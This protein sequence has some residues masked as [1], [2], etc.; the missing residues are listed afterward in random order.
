M[1]VC[2]IFF[3]LEDKRNKEYVSEAFIHQISLFMLVMRFSALLKGLL[4]AAVEE[5]ERLSFTGL[6]PVFADYQII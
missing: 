1:P 6:A 2:V 4:T 5:G 3:L